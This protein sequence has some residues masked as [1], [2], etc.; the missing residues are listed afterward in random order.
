[1][2]NSCVLLVLLKRTLKTFISVSEALL[3]I[4]VAI[5][6]KKKNLHSIENVMVFKFI[7]SLLNM[8]VSRNVLRGALIMI[9]QDM[10]TAHQLYF[11]YFAWVLIYQLLTENHCWWYISVVLCNVVIKIT[12]M[13]IL[14]VAVDW[15]SISF[16]FE[17]HFSF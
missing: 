5:M 9:K 8:F 2:E 11:S 12:W 10:F 14:T 7:N 15:V 3:W 17:F 6:C 16:E 4:K 13:N 1:M